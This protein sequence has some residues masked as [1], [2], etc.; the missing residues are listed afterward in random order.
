MD[1]QDPYVLWASVA[2]LLIIIVAIYFIFFANKADY[3]TYTDDT[4]YDV[5]WRWEW[6]K[7]KIFNLSCYCPECDEKLVYEDD[8]IL[9]KTY[10]LCE[11]CHCQK[12]VIGGGESRYALGIVEREI[13]RKVRTKTY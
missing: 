6:K 4:L 1:F 8:P 3:H 12:A 10:F 9:H 2:V 11:K 13:L 7:D 5:H